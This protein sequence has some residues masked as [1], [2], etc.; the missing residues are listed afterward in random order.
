MTRG[1]ALL[2]GGLLLLAACGEVE[3]TEIGVG[4]DPPPRG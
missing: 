2:A 4:F 3:S 1:R